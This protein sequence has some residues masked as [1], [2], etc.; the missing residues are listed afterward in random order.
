MSEIIFDS[1][2]FHQLSTIKMSTKWKLNLGN[3]GNRRSDSKGSSVEFSD[4][5]EYLLGDDI[6]KIDWNVYGRMNK[7]YVKQ[8][9]EEKEGMFHIFLDGSASMEFGAVKKSVAARRLAA[10]FAYIILQ[11]LDRVDLTLL[12]SKETFLG[13]NKKSANAITGK[14]AFPKIL[15]ELEAMEFGG[16]T[17]LEKSIRQIGLQGKGVS[18]IISDFFDKDEIEE[19]LKYLTYKKQQIILVQVLAK[20]EEN[21]LF[22]GTVVMHD[23]E[24]EEKIKLTMSSSLQKSYQK[25][26]C[27]FQKK[28]KY[29]AQKYQAQYIYFM[30]E[31]KLDQFIYE[32]LKKDTFSLR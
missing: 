10:V 31:Q 18:I 23:M 27:E 22:E 20:E 2:F 5:R 7:F 4:Y 32:G 16:T 11:N 29:A 30:T 14:R 12:S 6:R 24:T 15:K 8:F 21:P 13:K 19:V 28:L 9:M 26:F 1:A 25:A 17:Q 3:A